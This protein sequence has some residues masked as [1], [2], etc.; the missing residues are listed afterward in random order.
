MVQ[1]TERRGV[2]R[3]GGLAFLSIVLAGVLLAA[4]CGQ[5]DSGSDAES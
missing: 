3:R 5:K 4:G 1:S 2:R